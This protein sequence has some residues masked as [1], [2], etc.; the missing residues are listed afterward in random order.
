[1]LWR[2]FCSRWN[3]WSIRGRDTDFLDMGSLRFPY[4]L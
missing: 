1:L 3:S 4:S 2:I